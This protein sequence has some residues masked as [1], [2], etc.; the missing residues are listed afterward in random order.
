MSSA[1]SAPAPVAAPTA[2]AFLRPKQSLPRGIEVATKEEL[3]AGLTMVEE[4][5]RARR[6]SE[7]GRQIDSES[8][9]PPGC[10]RTGWWGCR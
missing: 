8:E 6:H 1:A 10:E 5:N 4:L 7:S 9:D 2:D 3:I